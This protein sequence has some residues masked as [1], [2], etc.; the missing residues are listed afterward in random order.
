MIRKQI[1]PTL[2]LALGAVALVLL[3]AGYTLMAYN[4]K[5]INPSDTTIPS[6]AQLWDGLVQL[7]SIDERSDTRWIVVDGLATGT[8]FFLGM[9]IS[10]VLGVLTGIL[11]GCY[12]AVEAFV[13]PPL[14]VFAKVVPT[15]AMAVFFVLVGLDLEM[16]L[17]MIV[18]GVAPS[19]AI[20]VYLA[21][22]SV[23][24]ELID[25]AY[26]LGASEFEVVW[27]AV[28]PAILPNI[29][30]AIRLAIGPALVYLIAAEML[31]GDEGF[32]YR[33]RLLQR[34]LDMNVVYLYISFLAGF[35]FGM[36][37]LLKG[38]TRWWCPWWGER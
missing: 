24:K 27:G 25:K 20:S 33:I 26:T 17:T 3:L 4:Q 36:D 7:A 1:S 2:R 34:R 38:L 10:V 35:G 15:A 22:K 16:Y 5:L 19:L 11:A 14:T 8:R 28:Y 21:A 13:V 37:A 18:F 31:V 30:D 29:L 32:G 6:W 23:P 9:T 12:E